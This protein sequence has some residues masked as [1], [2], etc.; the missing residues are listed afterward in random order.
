MSDQYNYS[1]Y[2]PSANS[3]MATI[4][5]IAGIVGLTLFPVLGSIVAL[6]TAGMAKREIAESGG[7]LGGENLAQIGM[8]LGWIGLVL[9]LCICCIIVSS[10]AIPLLMIGAEGYNFILPMGLF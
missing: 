9:G 5:L 4:S 8:I 3:T 2:Q 6:V 1:S 7:T 10:F